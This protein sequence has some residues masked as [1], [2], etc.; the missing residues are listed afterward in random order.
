MRVREED[1]RAG[2]PEPAVPISM[3][4]PTVITKTGQ[5]PDLICKIERTA[6]SLTGHSSYT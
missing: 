6:L 5:E 2:A 3:G 1:S 4:S